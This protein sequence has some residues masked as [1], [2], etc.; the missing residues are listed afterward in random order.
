MTEKMS[1]KISDHSSRLQHWVKLI[2]IGTGIAIVI[3]AV[4]LRIGPEESSS[5]SLA[6]FQPRVL[7]FDL[8][9]AIVDVREIRGGGP[10]KD[11]IPALT[12]PEMITVK[13]AIYLKAED[14]VIGVVIEGQARAYP[15]AI[16]N[17]HEI[18]NDT[19]GDIPIAVTYCPLC[20]SG[21]VHNRHTPLGIR[22]FG[23]SGLLYNS[24][25][26]MY[27]R[28]GKPESLWSQV[29]TKGISGPAVN[30][31]LT[32]IPCELTRWGTWI[33]RHPD[34]LVLSLNTGHQRNYTRNPYESYFAN[35]Q[36]MF[37]VTPV[38]NRLPNK[39]RVLGVWIDDIYRAYPESLFTE[40]QQEISDKIG[41]K[42]L[43]ILFD[44]KSK[45]MRVLSAEEGISWLYSFWFAWYALHP[46]TTIYNHPIPAA[47][48]DR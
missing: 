6:Q 9:N 12:H 14:R 41:G 5:T 37:P 33:A 43:T 29:K 35:Q 31:Q 7:E 20:D 8:S 26:L 17:Y 13:Q 1:M 19:I 4:L 16:L 24:N 48:N 28:G 38:D 15:L 3:I 21:A 11:G 45:T 32:A 27:D 18:V 22:N 36:L 46:D 44:R 2:V 10:P 42:S 25:V 30:K 47:G 40:G 34:S 23:V 39:E